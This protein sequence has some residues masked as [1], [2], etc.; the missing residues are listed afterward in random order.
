MAFIRVNQNH[1]Y[2]KTLPVPASSCPLCQTT[3]RLEMSFYQVQIES[4]NIHNTKKITASVKCNHCEQDVPSI[5]WNNGLDAF[6]KTEKK[7]I[8]VTTSF[9]IGT[10]GK[11]LLW[12]AGIFFGAIFLL[13]IVLYVYG[14][15]KSK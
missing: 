13:L 12:I 9:K 2:L 3:G 5:R 4:D 1:L 11:I 8:K 6:Y 7:Q 14:H 15:I 10:K